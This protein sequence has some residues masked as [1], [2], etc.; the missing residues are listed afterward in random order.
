MH[1]IQTYCYGYKKI[2]PVT[3]TSC[4]N[5]KKRRA[6]VTQKMHASDKDKIFMM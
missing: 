2:M 3:Q 1:A 4:V 6:P 5:D